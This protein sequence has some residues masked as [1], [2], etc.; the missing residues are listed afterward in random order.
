MPNSS[1]LIHPLVLIPISSWRLVVNRQSPGLM[2]NTPPAERGLQQPTS[3]RMPIHTSEHPPP[4]H[5]PLAPRAKRPNPSLKSQ[6]QHRQLQSNNDNS[7]PNPSGQAQLLHLDERDLKWQQLLMVSSLLK[8]DLLL[9]LLFQVVD[10]DRQMCRKAESDSLGIRDIRIRECWVLME[11]P[12]VSTRLWGGTTRTRSIS[13]RRRERRGVER[14]T[15]KL[16][17]SLPHPKMKVGKTRRS[18][19]HDLAFFCTSI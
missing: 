6:R 12:L 2:P 16:S 3:E 1:T 11:C 14:A 17:S 7:P 5:Q 8:L 10:K 19:G 18:D 4:L 15:I 9:G 13:R